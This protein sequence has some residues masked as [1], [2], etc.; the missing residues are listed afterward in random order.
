LV[1][2]SDSFTVKTNKTP[3]FN[4]NDSLAARAKKLQ[5][6]KEASDEKSKRIQIKE[7]KTI[8]EEPTNHDVQFLIQVI[9]CCV[10]LILAFL[11]SILEAL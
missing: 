3:V 6:I 9:R 8:S 1:L 10:V 7:V 11:F 4:K 5:A 2:A